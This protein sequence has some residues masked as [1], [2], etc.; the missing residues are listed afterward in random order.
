[1]N[2]LSNRLPLRSDVHKMFDERHFSF[3]PKIE[4][5]RTNPEG[6]DSPAPSQPNSDTHGRKTNVETKSTTYAIPYFVGHVFNSTPS[7]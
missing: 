3:V 2:A 6:Q 7:G 4:N 5:D 1:M